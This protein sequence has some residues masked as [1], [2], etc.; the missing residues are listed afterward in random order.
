M[1]VIDLLVNSVYL[2][3]FFFI[4]CCFYDIYKAIALPYKDA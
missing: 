4:I 1:Y 3:I 2:K